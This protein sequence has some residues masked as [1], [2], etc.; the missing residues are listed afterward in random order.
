MQIQTKAEAIALLRAHQPQL[1]QLGVNQLGLFGSFQRDTDIHDRSDV[2]F[3]VTF[4]PGHKT[5]DNFMHLSFFLEDLLGRPI[6]LLTP[7]S[8]SPHLG[9]HILK[10]VEYVALNP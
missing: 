7:E 1:Q 2:D 6:D 3:L 9:S 4:A 8:L 10:A 5:F